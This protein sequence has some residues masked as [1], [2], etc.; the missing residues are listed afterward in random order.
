[1][2]KEI[3]F[4]VCSNSSRSSEVDVII[5]EQS[6]I[7]DNFGNTKTSDS[8]MRSNAFRYV[9]GRGVIFLKSDSFPDIDR[10][11]EDGL[12]VYVQGTDKY[13]KEERITMS[14]DE[15]ELFASAVT[16]YN[17]H[18]S[19]VDNDLP[20][21]KK[22]KL[23]VLMQIVHPSMS[24][25]VTNQI[26]EFRDIEAVELW[27]KEYFDNPSINHGQEKIEVSYFILDPAKEVK[28]TWERISNSK[29][30]KKIGE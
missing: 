6:H 30:T 21:N 13:R 2:K 19:G 9:D 4:R 5:E 16:A 23:L 27:I 18:F 22:G 25:P 20:K 26:V 28:Y 1:M 29:V 14:F 12:Y 10:R 15:Y 8:F 24:T 3:R 11:G 7:G 17:K